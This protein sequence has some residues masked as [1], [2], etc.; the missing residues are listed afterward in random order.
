MNLAPISTQKMSVISLFWIDTVIEWIINMRLMIDDWMIRAHPKHSNQFRFKFKFGANLQNGGVEGNRWHF[1]QLE[2]HAAYRRPEAQTPRRTPNVRIRNIRSNG[3]QQQHH[4]HPPLH[5]PQQFYN[6][7]FSKK[8]YFLCRVY[9]LSVTFHSFHFRRIC[10]IFF[11][12]KL[13][14]VSTEI[15]VI[16]MSAGELFRT[17]AHWLT[18]GGLLSHYNGNDDI[19]SLDR[20]RQPAG[21]GNFHQIRFSPSV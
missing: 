19:W 12:L 11:F 5:L 7:N 20:V 6:R 9:F 10:C 14:E 13:V 17:R 16:W 2:E 1:L 18:S 3:G 15:P 8:F 4:P 21:F